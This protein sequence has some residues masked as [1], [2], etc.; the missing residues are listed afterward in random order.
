MD[1]RMISQPGARLQAV[2]TGEI[3]GDN[4]QVTSGIVGFDVSKQSDVGQ[5]RELCVKLRLVA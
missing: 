4:E 2:M 1:A 3:V 5:Y